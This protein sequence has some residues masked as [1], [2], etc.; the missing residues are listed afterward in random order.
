MSVE[1]DNVLVEGMVTDIAPGTA[2]YALTARFPQGV[3]AVCDAN[4]SDWMEYVYMQ[5]ERPADVLG[6][7]VIISVVDPNNNCYE[8]ARATS[9]ESG[10]FGCT[11]K[12]EVPGLY[13]V[14]ASFE[15]SKSYYG[16]FAETFINVESAP[17]PTPTATP[18][19]REPVGTYFTIST[20]VIIVAIA[21]VAILIL[22]R[23]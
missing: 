11:F 18:E 16:S 10:Y 2:K 8:V 22:R 4:M 17:E 13:T 14:V 15:G 23:R 7:E 6:V 20:I 21:I 3:P 19:P 5:K 9:D 1:D 12:P